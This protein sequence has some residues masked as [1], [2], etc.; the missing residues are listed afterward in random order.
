MKSEAEFA[1]ALHQQRLL[2]R[3]ETLRGQVASQARVLEAPLAAADQARASAHWLYTQRVWIAAA[4]VVVLVARPR[5]AWRAAR[6][7]WWLWRSALR[8][9]AW[10]AAAGLLARTA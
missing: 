2:L 5:R 6:L 4:A 1:L 8:A 3:S 9:Q 10:L 7:G